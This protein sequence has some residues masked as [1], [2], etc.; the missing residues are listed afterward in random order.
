[1]P[2]MPP[3]GAIK[4]QSPGERHEE[5]SAG[6]GCG[7]VTIIA[8][9]VCSKQASVE[10]TEHLVSYLGEGHRSTENCEDTWNAPPEVTSPY[11]AG[12]NVHSLRPRRQRKRPHSSLRGHD[13][14]RHVRAIPRIPAYSLCRW[15]DAM[16]PDTELVFGS[17]AETASTFTAGTC[18][19]GPG[20][21]VRFRPA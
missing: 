20:A 4:Q 13:R 1:M 18:A 6:S 15:R 3:S 5:W 11:T 16:Y 10:T 2:S 21:H 17:S 14:T 12:E 7:G 9:V 19:P 8:A